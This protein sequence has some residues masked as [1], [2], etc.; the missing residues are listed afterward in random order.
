MRRLTPAR[1]EVDPQ[2]A[3]VAPIF[4]P[5]P[6]P[7]PPPKGRNCGN[8]QRYQAISDELAIGHRPVPRLYL[9]HFNDIRR[10][11]ACNPAAV[12]RFWRR[13]SRLVRGAI[14]R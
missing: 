3:I 4:L 5:E 10:R 7:D 9:A 14:P 13:R 2:M 1:I 8:Q 6:T 12:R 11:G